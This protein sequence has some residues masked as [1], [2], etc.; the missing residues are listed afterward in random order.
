MTKIL[1]ISLQKFVYNID[2]KK[3]WV[4]DFPWNINL[5]EFQNCELGEK[6]ENKYYFYAY[7][8][9]FCKMKFGHYNCNIKLNNNTL[10]KI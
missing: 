1:F 7:I 6:I 4:V 9:Y 10:C 5:S 8:N 3:E 2:I